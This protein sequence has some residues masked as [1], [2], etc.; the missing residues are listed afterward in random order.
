MGKF[1]TSLALA[2]IVALP[3]TTLP[4]QAQD[5][6]LSEAKARLACGTGQVL[7]AETL[8]DGSIRVTCQQT[9]ALPAALAGFTLSPAAAGAITVVILCA[10][11]CGG[12]ES[13]SITTTTSTGSLGGGGVNF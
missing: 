12:S 1:L 11:L 9:N 13:E 10:A 8:A 7:G 2:A 4:A 5:Q 6:A 3:V